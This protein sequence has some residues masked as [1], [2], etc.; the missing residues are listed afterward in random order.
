MVFLSIKSYDGHLQKDINNEMV[1]NLNSR[2]LITDILKSRPTGQHP[3]CILLREHIE[4]VIISLII[5]LFH[6]SP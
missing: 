6:S 2:K 3:H 5:Y 1:K 4:K